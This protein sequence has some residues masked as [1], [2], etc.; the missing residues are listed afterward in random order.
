MRTL[1][2]RDFILSGAAASIGATAAVRTATAQGPTLMTPRSVQPRGGRLRRTATIQERRAGHV[3]REG[4]RGDHQGRRRARRRHRRRQIVELDPEDNSVGYGGLPNADG[5]VQLDASLHARSEEAGRRRGLRSKASGRR[6]W[7]RRAVMDQTDHHLLVGRDAQTFARK[8]GLHDRGRS[9]HRD[10][11]ARRG[12]SG[13]AAPIPST[14]SIP[15]K[16]ERG[17][18]PTLGGR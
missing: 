12:S 3:C 17:G 11:R 8:L 6:R 7:W 10:T 2:R 4:I 15:I 14:I 1:N 9:E 13:S 5:I 18:R 16:R